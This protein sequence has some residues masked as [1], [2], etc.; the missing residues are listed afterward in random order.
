MDA[1][2]VDTVSCGGH[3]ANTCGDCP[4]GHGEA[5]CNGDCA[6]SGG[7]C[8]DASAVDTVSC[9][10]H[11][12]NTCGECPQGHGAAWCNGDCVWNN[13]ECKDPYVEDPVSCGGHTANNCGECPAGNGA[14]W[15]N[16]DCAWNT[17]HAACFPQSFSTA[18]YN[19]GLRLVCEDGIPEFDA[20]A[21]AAMDA[22][23]VELEIIAGDRRAL[24]GQNRMLRTVKTSCFRHVCAG[25]PPDG[26]QCMGTWGSMCIKRR[27]LGEEGKEAEND[28]R[29]LAF[30]SQDVTATSLCNTV[31]SD[32]ENFLQ[33]E[34]TPA[35]YATVIDPNMCTISCWL[36]YTI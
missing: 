32:F 22:M 30:Y 25:Y 36:S 19:L 34:L 6:W 21:E 26:A 24:R 16:G 1:S 35:H 18:A 29:D 9:G 11:T 20:G 5:W 12:A 4:Q 10:G 3:T 15:C 7:L 17:E 28:A 8:M 14:S 13:N 2:A 23:E 33:L 31:I 27:H